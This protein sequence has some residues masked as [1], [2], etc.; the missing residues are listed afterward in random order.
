MTASQKRKRARLEARYGRPSPRAVEHD[1]AT[2]FRITLP[3][4]QSIVLW[5]DE[6][7]DYPRA[8]RR[9]DHLEVTHLTVSSRAAR[10]ARNPLFAINLLDLLIRHSGANHKRETIAYAKRRQ[11]AIYRF[12][13]FLVWRNWCKW[14]SELTHESTPAMRAGLTDRRLDPA[15]I[16]RRRLFVTHAALPQNWEQHYWGRVPTRLMPRARFHEARYAA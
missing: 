4:R 2:L 16:L 3:A 12:W 13:V 10:T 7:A 15:E 14:F 5:T 1:V 9:C 11:M 6:H 8:I